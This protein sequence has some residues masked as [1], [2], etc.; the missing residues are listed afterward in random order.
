MCAVVLEPLDKLKVIKGLATHESIGTDDLVDVQELE[1]F[2]EQIVV[3]V[4]RVVVPSLELDVLQVDAF[5]VA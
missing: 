5:P 4:V 2:L 1:G 3:D